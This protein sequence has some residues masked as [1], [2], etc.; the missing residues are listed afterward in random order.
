[1]DKFYA[2]LGGIWDFVMQILINAG[3][4]AVESWENPFDKLIDDAE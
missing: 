2:F 1:M 3:V 4:T